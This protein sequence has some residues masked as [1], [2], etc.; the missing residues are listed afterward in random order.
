LLPLA[1]FLILTIRPGRKGELKKLAVCVA[2]VLLVVSPLLLKNFLFAGNP[3]SPFL[4][5]VFPTPSW[6]G[7]RFQFLKADVGRMVRSFADFLRLPY[8]LSFFNH[9]FGGMVGPFFLVFLPFLLLGPFPGKKWLLWALLVLATTPFFTGSLRF[10]FAAIV[11]LAIFSLRAYESRSGKALDLIFFLIVAVNFTMGLA[12]L[13]KFYQGHTMLSGQ[14][15]SR[16]Y[17]EHFF[18][19]YPA[20]AYINANAPSRARILVAGEA[21][22]YYLKRPYQVSSAL[23]YCILNKYLAIGRS[24]DEFFAAL[25]RDGY[26]YLLISASELQRLQEGYAIMTAGERHRLLDFLGQSEPLFRHGSVSVYRIS[27]PQDP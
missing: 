10:A 13:E 26:S 4:A 17:I 12:L 22:N 5:G 8:A 6:D 18:P 16:Q 23:D 1:L 27:G 19:A 2:I 7:A 20:I 21:R 24:A 25:R 9:G 14:N 3:F 11:L 15:D